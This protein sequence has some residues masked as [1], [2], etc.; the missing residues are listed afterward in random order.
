MLDPDGRIVVRPFLRNNLNKRSL[1]IDLKSDAGRGLFLDLVPEVRRRP[2][3][4][5]SGHDGSVGLCYDVCRPP[6]WGSRVS[7]GPSARRL[8]LRGWP[9]MP[10]CRGMSGIYE[11]LNPPGEPPR[12]NPVGALATQCG[13][14]SP[15]RILAALRHRESTRRRATGRHRHVRCRV[16]AIRTFVMNLTLSASRLQRSRSTSSST[17]S[18]ANDGLAL[19]AAR[20]GSTSRSAREVAAVPNGIDDPDARYRQDGA[21]TSR[22]W[23]RP[24]VEGLGCEPQSR[25]ASRATTAGGRRRPCFP[26]VRRHHR[27]NLERRN[28]IVEMERV[29][30]D[31]RPSCFRGNPVKCRRSRKDRR[32]RCRGSVSTARDVLRTDLGLDEHGSSTS[33]CARE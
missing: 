27:P 28:M 11:F 33:S 7:V 29:D 2:P 25:R 4:L 10:R 12:A 20:S 6:S 26:L 18:R 14:C 32:R 5:Q 17:R 1:A 23:I 13:G 8:A 22:T 16:D 21:S 9:G 24:R 31:E 19:D 15:P 3:K 30:G